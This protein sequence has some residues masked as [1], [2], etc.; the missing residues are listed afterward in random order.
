MFAEYAAVA[1]GADRSAAASLE[2]AAAPAW[3]RP[4][5]QWIWRPEDMTNRHKH[6]DSDPA[7]LTTTEAR[8]GSPRKMNLI[9]LSASLV[10]A[11]I[12]GVIFWVSA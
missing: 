11:G 5:G 1:R 9:V 6:D 4:A 2:Q 3:Q 10:L 7:R 12:V 8:Q